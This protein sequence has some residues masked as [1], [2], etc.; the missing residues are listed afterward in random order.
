MRAN[1]NAVSN[2]E[3]VVVVVELLKVLTSW[4]P[5]G[6]FDG[7]VLPLLQTDEKLESVNVDVTFKSDWSLVG[8]SIITVNHEKNLSTFFFFF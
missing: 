3:P 8:C 4:L 6:H 1:V 2:F 5:I 7:D